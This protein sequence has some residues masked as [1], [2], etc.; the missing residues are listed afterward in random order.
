MNWILLVAVVLAVIGFGSSSRLASAYG[1]AVMGTM[2]TT[3][4]LTFFVIR[5]G[6]GYPLWLCVLATGSFFVVDLAFFAAVAT[7]ILDGGWFPLLLGMAIFA[8]M[9]TWRRGR[10]RL[11]GSLKAASIPLLPFLDSLFTVPPQRVP[12]Y[13]SVFVL[14]A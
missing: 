7:K 1:V 6:W 3:T 9:L 12:G 2:L 13:G 5:Y 11:M 14:N 10:S 8:V 4:F